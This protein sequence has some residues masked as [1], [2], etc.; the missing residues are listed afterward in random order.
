[1]LPPRLVD[2]VTP[3]FKAQRGFCTRRK[4][5]CHKKVSFVALICD[6]PRNCSV[7]VPYG[8]KVFFLKVV[9]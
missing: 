7:S 9:I 2:R 6:F 1:M 4:D 3:T 5:I 8:L